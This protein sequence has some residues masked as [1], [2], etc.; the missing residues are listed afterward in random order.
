MTESACALS[1]FDASVLGGR[2]T[3]CGPRDFGFIGCPRVSPR[4]A[5]VK[6]A[7]SAADVPNNP[8]F[9]YLCTMES[10][11]FLDLR[12]RVFS[13]EP[14]RTLVSNEIFVF[15]Q[16]YRRS[17]ESR[18]QSAPEGTPKKKARWN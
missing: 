7:M 5:L 1:G 16:D 8:T 9:F 4:Q 10:Y 6:R 3:S 12:S 2:Y 15:V 11:V 17:G 13:G 18:S 14:R